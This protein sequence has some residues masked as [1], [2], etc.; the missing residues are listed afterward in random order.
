MPSLLGDRGTPQA[1]IRSRRAFVVSL[2][3]HVALF[4]VV[5]TVS[6]RTAIELP[7]PHNPLAFVDAGPTIRMANVP[8]PP[9][10][11]GSPQKS[12]VPNH[13]ADET[14][15]SVEPPAFPVIA[16]VGFKDPGNEGS[17]RAS[18]PPTGPFNGP[19]GPGDDPGELGDR[20]GPGV[21]LPPPP[22]P[23]APPKTPI[24]LHSGVKAPLKIAHTAPSYPPI[25]QTA[26]V[27]GTVILEAIIS[28]SGQ[29]E[30]LRVLRSVGLLDDAAMT[31]VRQ[32]RYEPALLNGAPVP[33]II[34][35]TVDFR[36][37]P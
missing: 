26:R 23:P 35:I 8:P 5:A 36:L 37:A 19:E 31:A 11:G 7:D 30:S 28:E 27:Q 10:G 25:A 14:K 13:T 3:G 20:I 33:V 16:P 21:K 22:P 29:V 9:R 18:G 4:V 1:P 34:T 12:P 24:R 32:W 17:V 2:A 6:L 15:L